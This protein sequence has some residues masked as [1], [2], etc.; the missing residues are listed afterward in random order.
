MRGL[1]EKLLWIIRKDHEEGDRE[2]AENYFNLIKTGKEN[3]NVELYVVEK[4][5]KGDIAA[6]LEAVFI[7]PQDKIKAEEKG[8]K[9][10]AS[11]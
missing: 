10:H 1:R 11:N 3:K 4:Q 6:Y 9:K 2:T 8:F 5:G 7:T